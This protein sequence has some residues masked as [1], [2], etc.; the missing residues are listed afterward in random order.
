MIYN[1]AHVFFLLYMAVRIIVGLVIVIIVILVVY[2]Y[3][4]NTVINV[5][6]NTGNNVTSTGNNTGIIT[7]QADISDPLLYAQSSAK[8][9][10]DA[11]QAAYTQL[12]K[13]SATNSN[14][15]S[16]INSYGDL[17]IDSD[18]WDPKDFTSAAK[19]AMDAIEQI[20]SKIALSGCNPQTSSQCGYYSMIM[21]VTTSSSLALI[22]SIASDANNIPMYLAPLKKL[23]TECNDYYAHINSIVIQVGSGEG[24]SGVPVSYDNVAYAESFIT[25]YGPGYYAAVTNLAASFDNLVTYAA[26]GGQALANLLIPS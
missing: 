12:Q 9:L 15:M 11:M 2:Q 7:P 6:S 14:F 3:R 16:F 10:Y 18:P 8:N 24:E 22:Y 21:S 20:N 25:N 17:L 1:T 23:I 19:S 26:T 13:D 5:T 4:K